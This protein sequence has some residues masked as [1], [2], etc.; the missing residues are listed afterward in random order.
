MNMNQTTAFDRFVH[1]GKIVSA[2]ALGGAWLFGVALG[3]VPGLAGIDVH[4]IGAVV[5][6]LGGFVVNARHLV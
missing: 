4:A 2:F 5:G 1:G 3:W 6:G